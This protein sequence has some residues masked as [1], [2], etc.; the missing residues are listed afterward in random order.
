MNAV[1]KVYGKEDSNVCECCGKTNLK[2][3]VVLGFEDGSIKRYGTVCAA[4]AISG[5]TGKSVNKLSGYLAD[6]ALAIEKA[7]QWN[8]KHALS[9]A[10]N[11]IN[12]KGWAQ[13]W[14]SGNTL[15]LKAWEGG[16]SEVIEWTS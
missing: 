2:L 8:G 14:T 15:H 7:Q 6:Y 1:I 9:A 12:V 4:K 11:H 5:K 13:V 3:T 16:F 10:V